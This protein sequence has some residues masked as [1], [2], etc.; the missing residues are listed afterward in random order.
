MVC[1]QKKQNEIGSFQINGFEICCGRL[2]QRCIARY[3]MPLKVLATTGK[4][5]S[6]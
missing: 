6:W 5:M 3:A 4:S 1:R 2:S